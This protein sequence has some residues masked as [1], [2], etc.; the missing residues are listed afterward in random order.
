MLSRAVVEQI[1]QMLE[2][3]NLSDRKI[4]MTIGVSRVTVD[5][6]HSGVRGGWCRED[7][8]ASNKSNSKQPTSEEGLCEGCGH[9]VPLPCVYCG[10]E[11]H[12]RQQEANRSE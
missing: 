12:R 2:E 1:G 8:V 9:V 7:R 4:A 11:A 6:I 5:K 10:A 3:G